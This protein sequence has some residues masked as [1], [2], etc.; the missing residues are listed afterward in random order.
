MEGADMSDVRIQRVKSR[1]DLK[2]FIRLP[3]RIYEGDPNWVPPLILDV[4]EKLNKRKNPFFEHADMELFL[5]R[6]NKGVTGRIAAIVDDNHN[7]VH[8][9]KV[10]FFGMYESVDDSATARALLDHAAAWGRERGM[11]TLRGPMNLSLNDECAFLL[12]GFDSPPTVM[13]PYN[14]PFYLDLMEKSGL[15]KAKDL[16]A[17]FMERD[18][19]TA[20]K[21]GAITER[22]RRET[23][24][25]LRTIDVARAEEE[26]E[27][28]A[29]IYNDGWENNWGFVPWT[30]NEMRRMVKNLKRLADPSLVIIAE[31]RGRPAGFAFGLPNY[32]EVLQTMNGR[33]FPFGF[34]KFLLGRKN[35]K[36]LR[37]AVFGVLQAYR[38]TGL[39]Y[40]LYDELNKNGIARGYEWGEMSWQLEDNEAINRFAVSIGGRIYKKYRIFE[41]EIAAG[42]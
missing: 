14:P 31:D 23:K 34:I 40:L 9:E 38:H 42:A 16:Y 30:E 7:A 19:V 18:H 13:M 33:L 17:F 35:I 3:W 32:N 4:K 15:S 25:T 5:A 27:S 22:V 41:K 2:E 8:N 29:V 11:T 20:D 24:F 21:V 36:G 39:S 26:A 12:E 6:R 37:A 28:I 10:V 1:A